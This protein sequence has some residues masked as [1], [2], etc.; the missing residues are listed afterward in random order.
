MPEDAMSAALRERQRRAGGLGFG[1]TILGGAM[2]GQQS[3]STAPKSL[4]GG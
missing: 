2:G 1:S 3:A 4:L